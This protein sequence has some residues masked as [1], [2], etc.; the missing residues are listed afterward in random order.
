MYR[1]YHCYTLFLPHVAYKQLLWG[2]CYSSISK[3]ISELK[4]CSYKHTAHHLWEQ[5]SMN[6][7]NKQQEQKPK[8]TKIAQYWITVCCRE[9]LDSQSRIF[10]MYKYII[11]MHYTD[12]HGCIHAYLHTYIHAYIHDIHTYMMSYLFNSGLIPQEKCTVAT[13]QLEQDVPI[14]S[15]C[16]ECQLYVAMPLPAQCTV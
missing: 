14:G 16:L 15:S 8:T 12:V 13:L 4:A 1:V 7:L 3:G 2:N 6:N 11:I 10:L 9:E 5:L